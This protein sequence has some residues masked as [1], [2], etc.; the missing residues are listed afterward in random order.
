MKIIVAGQE[1]TGAL[2]ESLR[3]EALA[4]EADPRCAFLPP[5]LNALSLGESVSEADYYRRYVDLI[6]YKSHVATL[7]FDMP[8]KPGLLGGVMAVVRKFLWKLLRYQHDRITFRQNLV[9][10]QFTSA[11]EFQQR[12]MGEEMA[13]LHARIAD[14]EARQARPPEAP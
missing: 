1:E 5:H 9:N 8:R 11:F 14:L 2:G 4:R 7:A 3:R 12:L 13:R 10:T 6:R